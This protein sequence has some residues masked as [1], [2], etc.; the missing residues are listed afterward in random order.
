MV[1]FS[2]DIVGKEFKTTKEQQ[3]GIDFEIE[4]MLV[5]GFI[6]PETAALIDRARAAAFFKSSLYLTRIKNAVGMWR[7]Y[8]FNVQL[9]AAQFTNDNNRREALKDETVFVQG[10]IDC[11]TENDDGTYTLIDYKTD[12]IPFDLV[13]N[14]AEFTELLINRHA[15][16]LTYYKRALE[17]ITKKPVREV[18]IYSFALGRAVDI[19][20]QCQ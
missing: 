2:G 3:K 11:F 13:G 16:Q 5:M 8:R 1:F 15:S 6:S 14:E 19:T 17:I 10:I 18:L 9:P 12:R 4:R 20:S 7:E